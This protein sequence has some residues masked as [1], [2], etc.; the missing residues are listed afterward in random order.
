MNSVCKPLALALAVAAAF[1]SISAH[2]EAAAM[3]ADVI[4]TANRLPQAP[5]DVLADHAVISSE[6][7]AVSGAQSLTDLLQQQRAIEV[8]RNG[9]PGTTSSVFIRG[10]N[11]AQ[12]L[13]L[14]D[15]V[16]VGSSTTGGATWA[17]IPLAQIDHI[18]IIYGPLSSMYG[19]DAMGGVIQIFTRK[20]QGAISPTASIGAGSYGT[21]KYQAGVSGELSPAVSFALNAGHE[22]SDGFSA[23]TPAAGKYSYNADK[24]GY[25]LDGASGRID[26]AVSKDLEL[27]ANFMATYLNAQFDAGPSYDDRSMQ[28]FQTVAVHGKLRVNDQW[29]SNLQ[30]AQSTDRTLTDA[31]YGLSNIQTRQNFITWQND[32]KIGHDN[33]QL[34]AERREE[35]VSSTTDGVSG[36]RTTDSLAAA[37]LLKRDAHL[38]S[39]S[40][41]YDHSSVYGNNTTGSVAYGYRISPALRVNASYGTSFRAPTFNELYYPG[42][43]IASNKPETAK[44]AEAGIYYAAGDTELSAV[45]YQ[46]KA[47]DLLVSTNVCPIQQDSHPY[48]CAYNVGKA[49]MSGLTIGAQQHL[50]ALNLRGTLDLQDPKD[51][52]SGLV[53]ARRSKQHATLAADY[54]IGQYKFGA[55]TVFSGKRYDDVANRNVLGGYSLLNLFGSYTVNKEVTVFARW[56]N[57]L[58]KQ[59]QLARNYNTPGSNLFVGLNYGF[60]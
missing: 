57:A 44:N 38:A 26:W 14:V 21:Y 22:Q 39:A 3:A 54:Q 53:L 7:I 34:L 60:K 36:S 40:L 18:E 5:A 16:R 47:T 11:N 23:T 8:T 58:D 46:N 2:A 1:P 49:T 43:G 35:N 59:Y 19:A 41:R 12:N 4:V 25:K 50:G 13:V 37:Y 9:G 45:Y 56:N 55:E 30:F 32:L 15:G 51:D 17:D 52:T 6:E 31:S 29:T 42:Y 28:A 33:L 24:D 48:G 10:G 27:G 20:G